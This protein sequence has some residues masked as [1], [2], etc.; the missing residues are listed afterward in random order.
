MKAITSGTVP[1]PSSRALDFPA[2]EAVVLKALAREPAARYATAQDLHEDLERVAQELGLRPSN[3]ALG[4]FVRKLTHDKRYPSL[5]P[6]VDDDD[7]PTLTF[8]A[9]LNDVIT[10]GDLVLNPD[11]PPTPGTHGQSNPPTPRPGPSCWA[12]RGARGRRSRWPA[13]AP[14][15]SSPP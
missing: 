13:R 10:I 14:S 1:P 3:A 6:E 7:A 2:L 15:S 8:V 11:A 9:T 12:R 5:E 4:R